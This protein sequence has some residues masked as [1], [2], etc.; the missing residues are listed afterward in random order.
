MKIRPNYL[1]KNLSVKTFK[2]IKALESELNPT[3]FLQLKNA[4]YHADMDQLNLVKLG[5]GSLV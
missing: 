5:K 2:I 4:F 3:N 1:H